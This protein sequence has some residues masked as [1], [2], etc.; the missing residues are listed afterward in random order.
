[1]VAAHPRHGRRHLLGALP[2]PEVEGVVVEAQHLAA[3]QR[4]GDV[5]A[6]AGD[7]DRDLLGGGEGRLDLD[8]GIAGG[9]AQLP[10]EREPA[11]CSPLPRLVGG[12]VG[13]RVGCD[14]GDLGQQ[15]ALDA[16]VPQP[17]GPLQRARRCSLPNPAGVVD[18]E[19]PEPHLGVEC[20]GDLVRDRQ[21]LVG[22]AG[23]R[24]Q[25]E[26]PGALAEGCLGVQ[27]A[28]D[29]GCFYCLGVGRREAVPRPQDRGEAVGCGCVERSQGE[30]V[31]LLSG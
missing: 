19:R 25:V 5:D 2:N 4:S 1:M 17:S 21:H 10:G 6:A 27:G 24:V 29:A 28:V 12:G 26:R 14:E 13:V 8:R 30:H 9:V 3:G 20:A 7:G 31:T 23:D 22:G 11:G 16:G 15:L 18:R